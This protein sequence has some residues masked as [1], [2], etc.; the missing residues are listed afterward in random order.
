[1]VMQTAY[2]NLWGVTKAILVGKFVAFSAYIRKEKWSQ[3]D[4][5]SFYFK[6]LEK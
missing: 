5:I 6:I 2:Q 1:M 3:I 4:D